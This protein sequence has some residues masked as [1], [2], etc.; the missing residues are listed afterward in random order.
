MLEIRAQIDVDV[1]SAKDSSELAAALDTVARESGGFVEQSSTDA[2]GAR[3]TLRVPANDLPNVR[4]LLVGHGVV[5]HET[6]SAK[7]VTDAIADVDARVRSAKVEESRLMVLLEKQTGT[8]ADVLAV[9]KALADVRERV[10]RLEAEQR[11]AHGR[12]DL[13]TIEVN[14][15]ILGAMAEAP[16]SHRLAVAGRE[17]VAFARESAIVATTTVVRV[18]PTLGPLA[19]AG[20]AL[21][22]LTRR[23][24]AA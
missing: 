3:L 8:L 1:G 5:A 9:E 10:E 6:V 17:G 14:L 2:N 22:R 21:V 15:R 24:K 12:V 20:L 13:A 4:A 7:D 16:F 18:V 11:T 23:K 19:L